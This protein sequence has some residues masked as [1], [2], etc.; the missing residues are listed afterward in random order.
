MKEVSLIEYPGA[1]KEGSAAH[2][3]AD[4]VAPKH[5]PFARR[6]AV[7]R[8]AQRHGDSENSLHRPRELMQVVS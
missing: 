1:D 8:G 2:F 6:T 5:R 4:R 7:R 3:A